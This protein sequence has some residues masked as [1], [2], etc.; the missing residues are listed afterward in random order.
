MKMIM[1]ITLVMVMIVEKATLMRDARWLLQQQQLLLLLLDARRLC[2][3]SSC[4]AICDITI[5]SGC[6]CARDSACILHDAIFPSI[7]L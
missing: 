2:L 3:T 5:Q 6:R 1:A 7:S 4:A